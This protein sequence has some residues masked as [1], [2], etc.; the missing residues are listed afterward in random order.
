MTTFLLHNGCVLDIDSVSEDLDAVLEQRLWFFW[1]MSVIV[2][3]VGTYNQPS[4][5]AKA[6][7]TARREASD[8]ISEGMV[9]FGSEETI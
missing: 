2:Q 4:S 1:T 3:I 7:M 9:D 5:W 6:A 8:S